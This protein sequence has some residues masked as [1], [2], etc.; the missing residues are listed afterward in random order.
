MR[1]ELS[2][3]KRA[4][5]KIDSK[6]MYL[7]RSETITTLDLI[8]I[9]GIINEVEEERLIERIINVKKPAGLDAIALD[10]LQSS[11]RFLKYSVD[12]KDVQMV[13]HAVK[14]FKSAVRSLE[15]VYR[16]ELEYL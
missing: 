3:Y 9:K 8:Q 10:E 4:V 12:N 15:N 1:D 13:L 6:M 5:E 2:E 16:F 14:S 11:F 7:P